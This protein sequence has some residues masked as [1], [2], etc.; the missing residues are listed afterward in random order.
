M[1]S[2]FTYEKAG[3][4]LPS[5]TFVRQ[6]LNPKSTTSI[7][8]SATNKNSTTRNSTYR[9]G[10]YLSAFS[11]GKKHRGGEHI[12][13]L[14]SPRHDTGIKQLGS[15]QCKTPNYR[16]IPHGA[17]SPSARPGTSRRRKTVQQPGEPPNSSTPRGPESIPPRPEG[18]RRARD[19]GR[20]GWNSDP[21]DENRA[22][23]E[24]REEASGRNWDRG[25]GT[26]R[27]D[28]PEPNPEKA[29]QPRGEKRD[30]KKTRAHARPPRHRRALGEARSGNRGERGRKG[31]RERERFEGEGNAMEEIE[32]APAIG[33]EEAE[34]EEGY[35]ATTH[36]R[37]RER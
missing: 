4:L 10:S 23:I 31:G 16:C 13:T 11:R 24:R 18:K 7:K 21:Q 1:D 17:A 28:A 22:G 12:H 34:G 36:A 8:D 32:G 25:G 27:G 14:K 6:I 9:P 3:N 35:D 30:E 33:R 5:S 15:Q 19:E 26:G 20:E 2:L 37:R 29:A